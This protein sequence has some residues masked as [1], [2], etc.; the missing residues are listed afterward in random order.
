MIKKKK[1]LKTQLEN[2][3]KG[4]KVRRVLPKWAKHVCKLK[5]RNFTHLFVVLYS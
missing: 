1:K 5:Q 3:K 4:V 2:K